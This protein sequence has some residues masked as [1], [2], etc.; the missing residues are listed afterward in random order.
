MLLLVGN[1]PLLHKKLVVVD[2]QLLDQVRNLLFLS[3]RLKWLS[4]FW[5]VF[6]LDHFK[7]GAGLFGDSA[8][9]L[10]AFTSPLGVSRW[11]TTLLLELASIFAASLDVSLLARGSVS[12]FLGF[13]NNRN[14]F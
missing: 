3:S 11:L 13:H 9:H 12:L 2:P 8:L 14:D 6:L 7:T 1:L 5:R 4:S 10:L